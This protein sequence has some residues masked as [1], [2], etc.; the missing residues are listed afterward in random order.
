M[1]FRDIEIIGS[2]KKTR[3]GKVIKTTPRRKQSAI[4]KP[5]GGLQHIKPLQIALSQAYFI[6]ALGAAVRKQGPHL[7]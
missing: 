5:S 2:E 6:D 1:N 3:G 4:T 7:G